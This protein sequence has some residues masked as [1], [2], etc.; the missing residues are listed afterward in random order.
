MGNRNAVGKSPQEGATTRRRDLIAGALAAGAVAMAAT[1]RAGDDTTPVLSMSR[2][3]GRP[4]ATTAFKSVKRIV[5]LEEHCW[6]PVVRA[7]L[8][9]RQTEFVDKFTGGRLYDVGDAR[10]KRMDAAGIDLQVLSLMSAGIQGLD[11][12]RAVPIAREANDWIA[13]I[14]RTY[15]KRFAAFAGL[16]T[17]EPKAA[18]DELERAVTRLGCKGALINGHTQ[19]H[20]LDERPWWVLWERAQAWTSRSTSIPPTRPARSST[21][22]SRTLRNCPEPPGGGASTPAPMFCG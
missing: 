16:P 15:P 9:V 4:I 18:A 19:G 12:A 2:D 17:Q 8:D 10:I 3:A 11:P 6:A 14:V 20:Y 13:E 1:A 21:C 7:T 22:T 5:T